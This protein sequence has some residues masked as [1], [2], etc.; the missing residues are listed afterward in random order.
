MR[1]RP[2]RRALVVAAGL[3][4]VA[5]VVVVGLLLRPA[6]NGTT[7]FTKS[8]AGHSLVD[9]DLQVVLFRE[10]ERE[11]W[12]AADGSG[13][14]RHTDVNVS[15]F[16]PAEARRWS[17]AGQPDAG[18]MDQIFAAGQLRRV[19]PSELPA[20]SSAADAYLAA[21]PNATAAAHLNAVMGLLREAEAPAGARRLLIDALI[22]TTGI[23]LRSDA[24]DHV[25]RAAIELSA[26]G[27]FFGRRATLAMFVDAG[28]SALLGDTITLL[29]DVPG[30]TARAPILV[31]YNDYERTQLVA[32][33]DEPG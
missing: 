5:T 12:I 29:D 31:S 26:A 33:F 23:A 1:S 15:T 13:R 16:S 25:G 10:Y 18:G 17:E 20:N 2:A 19:D 9:Q 3:F 22:R 4:A 7:F 6:S 21:I 27:D 8:R 14:I 11:I 28:S 32:T 30:W 24:Q